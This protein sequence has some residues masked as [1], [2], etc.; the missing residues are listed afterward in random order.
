MATLI[1][2][3]AA[4]L[5][6]AVGVTGSESASAKPDLKTVKKQVEKLDRQAEAASERYNDAKVK[7]ARTQTKLT[8]LNSD[9]RRQQVK[10]DSMREQVAALVVE[11]FQGNALSTTSQLVLS[12]NPDAFLDNL[13]AVSAYNSQRGQV[14]EDYSTQLDRLKLRKKAV[15]AEATR[16]KALQKQMGAEKKQIDKK[17]A[18]AQDL[19]DD[20]EAQARAK[21]LGG[22][23]SGSIPT[24]D[25]SGKAAVALRYALAQ[26]GKRYVYGAAGPSSFDC[27]GL[28]MRAWGSAGVGLPHSSRAQTGSGLRVSEGDL[29]PGDLVFYYSPVS[30]VGMYLGNGLIV[31]A[32]NPSAGVRV[33]P[34]HS[35][36]Y[37]GAVRPG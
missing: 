27:S 16:L 3:L 18:K 21:L 24:F 13:N 28:T 15:Q 19:L 17:A 14:I 31:H 29:Q 2:L 10:V 30:H 1:A 8:A 26:V 7:V 12:N 36:P 23:Y 33:S 9:L 11:Q 34:L 37:V 22:D 32:A 25:G 6:V 5:V 35:M 20:L 4:L